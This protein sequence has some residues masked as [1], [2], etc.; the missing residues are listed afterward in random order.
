MKSTL[1]LIIKNDLGIYF[2]N[3]KSK[4]ERGKKK[5]QDKKR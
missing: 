5:R 2:L 1:L 3:R 4:K